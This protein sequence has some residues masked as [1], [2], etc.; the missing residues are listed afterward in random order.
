MRAIL[1]IDMEGLTLPQVWEAMTSAGIVHGQHSR[2]WVDT[3]DTMF[4]T[5]SVYVA[6][7][8]GQQV[9]LLARLLGQDCIA[10]YDLDWLKG[11]L[12]GPDA[13]KYEPFDAGLFQ[14]V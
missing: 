11:D 14:V 1:N 4:D 5:L 3:F 13:S 12:V 7:Q 6:L 9:D 2:G 8:S 10:M